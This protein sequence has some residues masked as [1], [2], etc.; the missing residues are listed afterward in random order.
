MGQD[1]KHQ[2]NM[3]LKG[4]KAMNRR[5][6]S[7]VLG[8]AILLI[9]IIMPFHLGKICHE[10]LLHPDWSLGAGNAIQLYATLYSVTICILILTLVILNSKHKNHKSKL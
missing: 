9:A 7:F 10:Y 3:A 6:K 4:D 5:N 8:A 2:G 1:A